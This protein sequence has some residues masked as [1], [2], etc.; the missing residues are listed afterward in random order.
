MALKKAKI[1]EEKLFVWR[2]AEYKSLNEELKNIS[3]FFA[4]S[5]LLLNFVPQKYFFFNKMADGIVSL[6]V[7]KLKVLRD[8]SSGEKRRSIL[9]L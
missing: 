9:K 2:F 3:T 1:I 6:L 7:C 4:F 5:K 8:R